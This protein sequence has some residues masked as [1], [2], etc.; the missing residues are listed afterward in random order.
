MKTV[1]ESRYISQ[2]F[3]IFIFGLFNPREDI[4][5]LVEEEMMEGGL[6]V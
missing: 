2:P 6:Y 3:V 4:P 1:W 5:V